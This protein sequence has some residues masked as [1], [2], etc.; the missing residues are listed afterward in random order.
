MFFGVKD[1]VRNQFSLFMIISSTHH[2]LVDITG[3]L[4]EK[5][6]KITIQNHSYLEQSIKISEL[7]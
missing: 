6:S 4:F 1:F 3:N 7:L 5:A 2:D